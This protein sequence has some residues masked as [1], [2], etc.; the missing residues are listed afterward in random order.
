MSGEEIF[1]SLDKCVACG[2]SNL[3][4][5]VDLG[6]QPLAN[7]FTEVPTDQLRFP[8]QLNYC[9]TCTHLQLS[10]CVNRK[11]IFKEYL[12]VSGTTETLRR[13]FQNF[14][15]R[16]TEEHGLGRIL[17]IACND[18]SQLDEFKKLGWETWGIDPAEN[19]FTISSKNHN[20]ICEFL[21]EE[22]TK[23]GRFDVVIAQ[24]VLAHTDNPLEFMRIASRLSDNIYIQTSQANMIFEGQFD[25]I[26][27][28]HISFFSEQSMAA[29]C[30]RA[31][32]FLQSV[33][34]RA[35]HG[36]SFL[37]NIGAN[38]QNYVVQNLVTEEV[39]NA[40]IS[41]VETCIS[42]LR[43]CLRDLSRNSIPIIGYGAAAKGMTVLNAVGEKID[44]I[45]DDSPLKQN[46]FTPGLNIPIYSIDRLSE[47]GD[48][49]CLIP[50]AWNFAEEI[51]ERVAKVYSGEIILLK[52]FPKVLLT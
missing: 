9:I 32:V 52:Y 8:L 7:A 44:F 25:T 2:S 23:L 46:T 26:Y 29:L 13:D 37:F 15:M 27:H 36:N 20:V 40:F 1:W 50:L 51:N 33:E 30:A 35:I 39:I 5:V 48:K 14:A 16:I 24:N 12:Y 3:R 11:E 10:H 42:D 22:H 38:E 47:A 28:E 18:G 21:N 41:R 19:L 45:I 4:K 6:D 49:I 34:N 17:D 31:G 43:E